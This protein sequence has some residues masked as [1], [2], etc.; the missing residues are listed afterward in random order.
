[1]E[2]SYKKKSGKLNSLYKMY[3]AMFRKQLPQSFHNMLWQLIFND[4]FASKHKCLYTTF[5][6]DG[7]VLALVFSN[8]A[9]YKPM[10]YFNADIKLEDAEQVADALNK[11][12]FGIGEDESERIVSSSMAVK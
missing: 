3:G 4:A 11:E 12:L 5:D 9:G 10:C 8:E 2:D 1:M 7:E 6:K